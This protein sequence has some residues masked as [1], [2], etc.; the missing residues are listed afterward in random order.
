MKQK[1]KCLKERKTENPYEIWVS[2]DG[3]WQWRVLKKWQ[4]DDDKLY[5]RWFCAV[6][7]PMTMGSFELGDVYVKE[8]K[9]YALKLSEEEMRLKLNETKMQEV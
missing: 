7:S 6:K 2:A 8:I 3:T 9:Q 4:V 1:N 5:A